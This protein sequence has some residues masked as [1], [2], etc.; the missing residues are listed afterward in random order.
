[1]TYPGAGD[2]LTFVRGHEDGSNRPPR[3]D[4]RT[5]ATLDGTIVCYAGPRQLAGIVDALLANGRSAKDWTAVI[6]RG[7]LPCQETLHGHLGEVQQR[8]REG[9]TPREPG[10]L[11]VGAV[12][13]LRDHLRWFDAR[14]LFGKRVLVTRSREQAGELVE[15]LEDLGAEAIEAPSVRIA[16]PTDPAPLEEACAAAG[17]YDWIIFGSANGVEAFLRRLLAGP[18]DVRRLHGPRLCAVG[19]GTAERLARW[20]IKVDLQTAEFRADVIRDGM[21]AQGS[22]EGTKVL[23]PRADINRDVLA[24]ELRKAGAKVTEVVAYRTVQ[25]QVLRD[26]GGHD[27]YRMLLDHQIDVVMFTSASTVRNFASSLGIEQAADL[28]RPTV[29]ACIGPVTAAAAAQLQIDVTVVAK[30]YTIAGLV[31]ALVDHFSA[32]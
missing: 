9:S 29:V 14:P 2:T 28:L 31:Q 3:V 32:T 20:G 25:E 30:D 18:G 5:L 13:G 7:T 15:L 21:R 26:H 16:P 24:D 1:V 12:A 8:L 11:V 23:V 4:W 19:S 27:I 22:L 6:W 17:D 10:I